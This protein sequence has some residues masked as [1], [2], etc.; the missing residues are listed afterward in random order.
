MAESPTPIAQS[1]LIDAAL[2]VLPIE[3]NDVGM[4]DLSPIWQPALASSVGVFRLV[5]Q[6]VGRV[7]GACR[8]YVVK[9]VDGSFRGRREAGLYACG[10]VS[11][12]LP[13]LVS[14]RCFG[15]VPVGGGHQAIVLEDLYDRFDGAWPEPQFLHVARALGGFAA[16]PPAAVSTAASAVPVRDVLTRDGVFA[17]A[18]SF[19]VAHA[20]HP[21]VR[22]RFA[23]AALTRLLF[24]AADRRRTFISDRPDMVLTCHGDAQRRNFV[25]LNH[26]QIGVLDWPNL[27]MAPPALDVATL[28]YYACAWFDRELDGFH[29]FSEA[30]IASYV[31]GLVDAGW[32][33]DRGH[34]H[35]SYYGQL[36][37]GIGVL[38]AVNAIRMVTDADAA[39]NATQRHG[40]PIQDIV[41]RRR[42]LTS[43][44]LRIASQCLAV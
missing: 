19:M 2:T 20:D 29:R 27:A 40:R 18:T 33:G 41:E 31:D 22:S 30:M 7:H 6:R 8:S 16:N 43:E 15:V 17:H 21:A 10:I 32:Q 13:P 26:A 25:A 12:L 36:V 42:A 3:H 9:V 4:C 14:A 35:H 24:L 38:E 34:V 28:V 11:A 23:P 39:A 37:L 5:V 44:L 1:T